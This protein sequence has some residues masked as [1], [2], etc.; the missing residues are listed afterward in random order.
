VQ[1]RSLLSAVNAQARQPMGSPLLKVSP[2]KTHN[3]DYIACRSLTF[4]IMPLPVRVDTKRQH[5]GSLSLNERGFE[6]NSIV[7]KM[8]MLNEQIKAFRKD[9]K[10]ATMVEY[11]I[12]ISLIA[13]IASVGVLS[14]GNQL[15]AVF[16]NI[17]A[18]LNLGTGSI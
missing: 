4:R 3:P 14:M 1:R 18:A 11:A 5:L 17:A 9:E 10:G 6:M 2:T 7:F 13:V 16:G 12:V 8:M 15:N